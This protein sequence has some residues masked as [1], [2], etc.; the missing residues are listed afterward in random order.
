MPVAM[1]PDFGFT[2]QAFFLPET[3]RQRP[4]EYG[5]TTGAI[6]KKGAQSKANH[7][8][9]AGGN[10]DIGSNQQGKASHQGG[11]PVSAETGKFIGGGK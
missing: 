5:A 1:I 6:I 2:C 8:L 4:G 11:F 7:I 9:K 10:R 3:G